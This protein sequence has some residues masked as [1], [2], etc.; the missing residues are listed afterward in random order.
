[1]ENTMLLRKIWGWLTLKDYDAAKDAAE[2]EIGMRY[3][4]GNVLFQDGAR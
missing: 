4:R 3:G 1:M 2:T